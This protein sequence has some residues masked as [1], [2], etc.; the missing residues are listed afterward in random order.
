M[1]KELDPGLIDEF[2]KIY[3]DKRSAIS[4]H[5][6]KVKEIIDNT[7]KSEA[8]RAIPVTTRMKELSAALDSLRRIQAAKFEREELRKRMI[9]NGGNWETYWKRR[10]K[11]QKINDWG[12]FQDVESML[13]ALHDFGGARLCV[14]FP[15]DIENV[16]SYLQRSKLIR[17]V[18]IDRKA[19][20]TTDMDEL[21]KYVRMLEEQSSQSVDQEYRKAEKLAANEKLFS[22]DRAV[23]LV[24]E[25][26]GDAVPGSHR[27]SH[28]K[29][30]IQI[31]TV[32]M[33][34][35]SQVEHEA[36]RKSGNHGL[37]DEERGVLD[38]LNGLVIAGEGALKQLAMY[39][40]RRDKDRPNLRDDSVAAANHYELGAW[41]A[42]Y[43]DEYSL[44][45]GKT[46]TTPTWS[47]LDKLLDILRSSGEHTSGKL[48]E[49][50]NKVRESSPSRSN[51][52][53]DDLA[54]YLLKAKFDLTTDT[55]PRFSSDDIRDRKV[56]TA[57]EARYLAF[58]V[59]HSMNMASYLG[60]IDEFVDTMES[61]LPNPDK[62]PRPTFVDFLDLLSPQHSR[63]SRGSEDRM[64]D[65]CETFLDVSNLKR[66]V[67]NR[68]MLLRMELPLL[69]TD[70]GRVVSPISDTNKP[71]RGEILTIVPRSLFRILHDPEHTFMVPEIL[72]Y[73]E[74]LTD[75]S[76]GE[77]HKD[78]TQELHITI[79]KPAS[80]NGKFEHYFP[81]TPDLPDTIHE[82]LL[83]NCGADLP[84]SI[85]ITTKVPVSVTPALRED[86][87]DDYI[88]TTED[89]YFEP[90][91]SNTPAWRYIE[92]LPTQWTVN[93]V[94][95]SRFTPEHNIEKMARKS[96]WAEF[97]KY[98]KPECS[99]TP[100][101]GNE[102]PC[103]KYAFKIGKSQFTLENKCQA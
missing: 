3:P 96:Q 25:L 31:S 81:T 21:R 54:L 35:W 13:D 34:A 70:I 26:L 45:P 30:E 102:K 52:F 32:V 59:V 63:I 91:W 71:P 1:G 69:L 94:D 90:V 99:M 76:H 28:Y 85:L 44:Y 36:I 10:G 47:E 101:D 7:T 27:D 67:K 73:A 72:N 87:K 82:H 4:E 66:V 16:V 86:L 14:Y 60:F 83:E 80:P 33:H 41:L 15:E 58:L 12:S 2:R 22:G 103:N 23:H 11:E 57:A 6:K 46:E 50:L 37:S 53:G 74:H 92:T 29:V 19:Q 78:K 64:I 75:L 38:L 79:R 8:I 97:A 20:G 48:R 61:V 39:T 9:D 84:R 5:V 98:L 18:Q 88:I 62:L 65:F 17:V 89:G 68:R 24:V 43:C 100:E 93:T 42:A 77:S 95:L 51:A 55:T 49:L 40:A 56:K